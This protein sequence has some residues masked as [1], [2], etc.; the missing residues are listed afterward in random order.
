MLFFI[1][2]QILIEFSVYPN[3]G[4]P[5]QMLQNAA[6]SDLGL[7]CLPMSHKKDKGL[8]D[9]QAIKLFS[10]STQLSFFRSFNCS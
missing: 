2:I 9:P 10:F 8:F 6:A 7:H 4:D 1:F 3:K 5:D